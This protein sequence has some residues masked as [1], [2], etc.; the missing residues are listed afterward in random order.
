MGDSNSYGFWNHP[1]FKGELDM[2]PTKP[3][4]TKS[5]IALIVAAVVGAAAAIFGLPVDC[6]KTD[7][8]AAAISEFAE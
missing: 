5:I 7:D 3:N 4:N 2:E 8:G 6:Q 1:Y